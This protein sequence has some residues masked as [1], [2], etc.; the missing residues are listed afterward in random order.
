[1]YKQLHEHWLA[2]GHLNI[3]Q[4]VSPGKTFRPRPP[5]VRWGWGCLDFSG[6]SRLKGVFSA[7]A[8]MVPLLSEVSNGNS[9]CRVSMLALLFR[10]LKGNH[11]NRGSSACGM[12]Q[13]GVSPKS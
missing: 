11:E 6:T 7:F 2:G 13:P 8:P 3:D 1:M 10:G 4:P 12:S 5:S 9:G